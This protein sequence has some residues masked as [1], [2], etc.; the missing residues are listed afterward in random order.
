MFLPI[1]THAAVLMTDHQ[2]SITVAGAG[3]DNG[4][5][6]VGNGNGN[7]TN[8]NG[9]GNNNST[10]GAATNQHTSLVAPSTNFS[11]NGIA[12]NT[13]AVTPT[14]TFGAAVVTPGLPPTMMNCIGLG[15]PNSGWYG[16]VVLTP[17]P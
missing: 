13:V 12:A 10:D 1:S 4:N 6:N 5:G 14:M 3:N 7:N 2:L 15:V 17:T 11:A 8:D 16:G 9:T